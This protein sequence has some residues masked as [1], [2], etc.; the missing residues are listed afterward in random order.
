MIRG[1][2]HC[3]ALVGGHECSD[4][5]LK[6]QECTTASRLWSIHRVLPHLRASHT[7]VTIVSSP[8]KMFC[9]GLRGVGCS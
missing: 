6:L 3:W 8:K 2:A 7:L 5:L 4:Q 9:A 1:D